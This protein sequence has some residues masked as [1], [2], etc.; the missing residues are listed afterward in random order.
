MSE[1]KPTEKEDQA[2][3][4]GFDDGVA[5]MTEALTAATQRVEQLEDTVEALLDRRDPLD[6]AGF[7]IFCEQRVGLSVFS[8]ELLKQGYHLKG[9][10]WLNRRALGDN[11]E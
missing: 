6:R 7:C 8:S 3:Q 1:L 11:D 2:W 5:S 9:C 4:F 10:A